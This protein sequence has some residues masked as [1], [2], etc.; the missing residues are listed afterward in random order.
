M[1]VRVEGG[2][3]DGIADVV[4]GGTVPVIVNVFVSILVDES[5]EIGAGKQIV[6]PGGDPQVADHAHLHV[7]A[8]LHVAV[9]EKR[10]LFG[11]ISNSKAGWPAWR[12]P[13]TLR[14]HRRTPMRR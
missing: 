7:L 4:I 6:L 8:G 9:V 14:A 11:R 10:A 3:L 12:L 2:Q 5:V 1:E 13:E